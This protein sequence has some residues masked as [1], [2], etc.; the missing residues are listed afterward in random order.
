[1]NPD[2]YRMAINGE[3]RDRGMRKWR[4]FASIPEQYAGLREVFNDLNTVEKPLLSSEQ[5]ESINNVLVHALERKKI[6][7][8]VYYAKGS[9]ITEKVI[10]QRVDEI[11]NRL[12]FVEQKRYERKYIVLTNLV[13]MWIDE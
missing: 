5:M 6:A 11:Q 2:A 8:I 12:F 4:A 1:M 3:Y 9:C 10:L 7:S 13:N